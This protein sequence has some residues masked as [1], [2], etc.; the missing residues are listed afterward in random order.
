MSFPLGGFFP[1]SLQARQI[2]DCLCLR[3]HPQGQSLGFYACL[4]D[5]RELKLIMPFFLLGCVYALSCHFGLRFIF[6]CLHYVQQI[7]ASKYYPKRLIYRCSCVYIVGKRHHSVC[8]VMGFYFF[9][10]AYLCLLFS[11]FVIVKA[12]V[13]DVCVFEQVLPM[14]SI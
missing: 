13:S 11:I 6:P 9:S 8:F 10:D 14:F 4:K 5:A 7:S 2:P 1:E 3:Y 12:V